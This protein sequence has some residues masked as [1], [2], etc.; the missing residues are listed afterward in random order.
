METGTHNRS[1]DQITDDQ[2]YSF[3]GFTNIWGEPNATGFVILIQLVD[4]ETLRIEK[5]TEGDGPPWNFTNNFTEFE[6]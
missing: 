2:I 6:R 1:F 3:S 4:D 5:Q